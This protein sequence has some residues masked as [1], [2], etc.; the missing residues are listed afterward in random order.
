MP[1]QLIP[2]DL[3]RSSD[4]ILFVAHLAIGDFTY[5]Q[6]FFKAFAAQNPQ[7]KIDLWVDEVRRTGDASKWEFLRKYSLYDWLAACPFF[8]KVY[9]RTYSPALLEESVAEAQAAHYP[10]VV[11]LATLR[12]H[13]YAALARRLSPQGMVIGMQDRIRFYQPH[14]ILA[15]RKLD[16]AIPRYRAADGQHHITDV[17]AHWFRQLS[18]LEVDA[19]ARMPFVEIPQQWREEAQQR[20]ASW[21]FDNGQRKLV[22]INPYAKTKKRCWS[23]AQVGQLIKAMQALPQWAQ[24][25]FVINAVPQELPHARQE[26]ARQQLERTV[27]FS[28]EENFF[29]LPALLEQADL[30]ISV[31]TAVMHLANAVHVPVIA[32]MRQK[33]PE[34]VPYDAAH[35][36]VVTTQ[37]RRDWVE[38]ISVEQVLKAIA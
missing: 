28:A 13:Q 4:R 2:Q 32:L 31:E 37:A 34:W 22:V 5:L 36:T 9:T 20:L 3:L 30:I 16:A 15:Y 25:D 21:G 12:P 33:N 14:H 8:N 24:S 17:Y 1:T 29:Q 23:L 11:S 26:I 18:G 19:A 10:I 38:R 6:N 27:L 35:S 7:L